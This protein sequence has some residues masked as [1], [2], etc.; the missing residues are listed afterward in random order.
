MVKTLILFDK[1]NSVYELLN[2]MNI[3]KFSYQAFYL[4][5]ILLKFIQIILFLY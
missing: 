2:L 1:L 5:I 4:N 3:L